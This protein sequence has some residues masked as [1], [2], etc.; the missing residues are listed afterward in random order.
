MPW[1][2]KSF[3]DRH[4]QKLKGHAATVASKIATGLVNKGVDEGKAIRIANA[5]GDKAMSKPDKRYRKR[6]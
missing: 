6:A 3:A 1:G 5:A 2:P 4:N